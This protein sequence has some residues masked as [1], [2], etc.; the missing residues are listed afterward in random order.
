MFRLRGGLSVKSG[1]GG[2]ANWFGTGGS[3]RLPFEDGLP[4]FFL[5]LVKFLLPLR[6]RIFAITANVAAL[7][8]AG[9][10][11][12]LDV[13]VELALSLRGYLVAGNRGI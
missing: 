4:I 9:A 8:T 3:T 13:I 2:R 10:V 7:M 11:T 12:S 1:C 5:F 6:L